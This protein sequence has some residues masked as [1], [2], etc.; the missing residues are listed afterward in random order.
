MSKRQEKVGH[1]IRDILYYKS[2]LVV[3]P[4]FV[5]TLLEQIHYHESAFNLL[6][7]IDNLELYWPKVVSDVREFINSCNVCQTAKSG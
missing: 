5:I 1:N 6:K 7:L 2:K 4:H 3:P